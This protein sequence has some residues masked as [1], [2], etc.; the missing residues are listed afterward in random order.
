M[1]NK[2][3][4]TAKTSYYTSFIRPLLEYG[5]AVFDNCT[6]FESHSL[7]LIQRRAALLCTGAFRRTP[8]ILLRN[9]V[10]WDTLANR[11]KDAKIVLMFKLINDLTP[12]YLSDLI[13]PQVQITTHYPLRNRTHFRVPLART[14][15][16]KNSF[17]PATL[18]QW[19]ALD[20][21]LRNCR[22]LPTF[23][24]KIK[25]KFKPNPL[26]KV[27]STCPGMDLIANSKPNFDLD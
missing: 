26:T 15:L 25:S 19:N 8:S 6:A 14:Q 13:P 9:E 27:Y 10:G 5:S 21:D 22:T 16:N 2:L 12:Q 17:I 4:R 20:P 7:E 23:K 24:T 3:S 11:R 18:R 1:K